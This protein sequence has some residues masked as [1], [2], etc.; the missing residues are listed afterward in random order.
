VSSSSQ[1][2]ISMRK[3]FAQEPWEHPRNQEVLDK[4]FADAAW[5]GRCRGCGAIKVAGTKDEFLTPNLCYCEGTYET[6]GWLPHGTLA[7][8]EEEYVGC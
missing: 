6:T 3:K 8:W 2:R 7:I 1:C 5:S 4:V